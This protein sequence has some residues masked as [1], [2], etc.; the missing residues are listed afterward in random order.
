M[1]IVTWQQMLG[2]ANIY[3]SDSDLERDLKFAYW[4]GNRRY[5]IIDRR[6]VDRDHSD[7]DILIVKD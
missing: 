4:I 7:V 5:R 3:W 1:E 2:L 6:D